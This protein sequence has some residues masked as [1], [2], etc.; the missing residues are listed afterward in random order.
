M[1]KIL[2]FIIVALFM[3]GCLDHSKPMHSTA[4]DTLI[5]Y[6]EPDET[7][8]S[9]AQPGNGGR[10]LLT[11]YNGEAYRSFYVLHSSWGSEDRYSKGLV[12]KRRS[13]GI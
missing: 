13:S 12:I 7:L 1:S 2:F 6:I 11:T 9:V 4:P 3:Y 8:V 10:F 5:V